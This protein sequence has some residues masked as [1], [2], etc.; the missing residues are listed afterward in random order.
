MSKPEGYD[1]VIDMTRYRK[2]GGYY[3]NKVKMDI[4]RRENAL[5]H[6]RALSG[7]RPYLV[8]EVWKLVIQSTKDI[9]RE[10]SG[11][12]PLV[13]NMVKTGHSVKRIEEILRISPRKLEKFLERNPK[14]NRYIREARQMRRDASID[15]DVDD[16]L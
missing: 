5:M 10:I 13:L 15:P 6:Q 3:P 11:L 12:F 1:E 2:R 9:E 8:T 7:A 16:L 14:L 4:W